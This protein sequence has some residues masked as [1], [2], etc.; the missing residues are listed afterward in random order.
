MSDVRCFDCNVTY[1]QRGGPPARCCGSCGAELT[2]GDV[3][4]NADDAVELTGTL[5]CRRCM[6]GA[7]GIGEVAE[8]RAAVAACPRC[9]GPTA[10][11][12]CDEPPPTPEELAWLAEAA[13]RDAEMAATAMPPDMRLEVRRGQE[14]PRDDPFGYVEFRVTMPWGGR[15]RYHLGLDEWLQV[16][17]GPRVI[18]H[19]EPSDTAIMLRFEALVGYDV[20]QLEH[21]DQAAHASVPCMACGT[22]GC[23]GGCVR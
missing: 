19:L 5:A 20:D 8:A 3:A 16:D 4:A 6:D 15:I 1:E 9:G 14:G 11:C 10:V 12:D 2:A 13:V 18:A 23:R 17:G 22:E 21:W 7:A